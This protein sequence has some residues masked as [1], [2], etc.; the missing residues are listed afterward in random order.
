MSRFSAVILS[1]IGFL[2]AVGS[3]LAVGQ[4]GSLAT[5]L[6]DPASQ[7]SLSL[8]GTIDAR[9]LRFI[10]DEMPALRALDLSEVSIATHADNSPGCI[11]SGLF[12]DSHLTEIVFPAE[13]AVSIGEMA[14]TGSS[15]TAV[16]LSPN[17]VEIGLGAFAGCRQL[18]KVSVNGVRAL[19]S[20]AFADCPA[21]SS[22][23]IT[24]VD[25]IGPSAFA[26][27]TAL[28]DISGEDCLRHI[29]AKAFSGCQALTSFHF[30]PR[31]LDISDGAFAGCGLTEIDLSASQQLT[32]VSA[33]AFSQCQSLRSVVLPPRLGYLS[34]AVFLGDSDVSSLSLPSSL[35]TIADYALSGLSELE[36]VDLPAEL[37]SIGA[38]AMNGMT[39]LTKIDAASLKS[40]PELGD[41]VWDGV[42]CSSVR[43]IVAPSLTDEFSSAAQWCEF[44]IAPVASS[45]SPVTA[46]TS[47]LSCRLDGRRLLVS[48]PA[49]LQ[50]VRI[51]SSDG[52][53]LAVASGIGSEYSYDASALPPSVILVEAMTSDGIIKSDKVLIN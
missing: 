10:A 36:T 26:G 12:A 42:A 31:L 17:I 47:D 15:L 49:G 28:T 1:L 43:L 51:Y 46:M 34:E 3:S 19:S 41:D 2:P 7:T 33:W 50:K 11:P 20:H 37:G 32:S 35:K 4:P 5:L 18:E 22:L 9:D 25:S 8:S 24:A 21:L 23:N 39:G 14:F 30:G 6:S 45:S 53:L 44:D 38:L 27:C 29:A 40:V 13:G 48:S 16:T 52:R